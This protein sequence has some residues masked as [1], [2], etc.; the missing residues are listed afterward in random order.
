MQINWTITKKRGNF[1]PSLNYKIT[2]EVFEKKLAV[3][4]ISIKSTIPDIPDSHQEFCLPD[5]NERNPQWI[6]SNFHYLSVPYFKK[7]KASGFIRLPFRN[8]R[9]YPEVG[10]SFQQLRYEYEAVV[11]QAYCQKPLHLENELGMSH[12]TKQEIAATITAAAIFNNFAS[13]LAMEI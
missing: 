4:A 7:G 11:R 8:S 1:R 9:G 13:P 5:S 12:E 6:A 2:L 3:N 10:A